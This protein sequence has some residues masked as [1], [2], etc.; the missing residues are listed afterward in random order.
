MT[1]NQIIILVVAVV[2]IA[3]LVTVLLDFCRSGV[4]HRFFYRIRR[5]HGVKTFKRIMCVFLGVLVVFVI[6]YFIYTA[7]QL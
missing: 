3:I 6:G 2:I 5:M 4:L 1:I 7:V